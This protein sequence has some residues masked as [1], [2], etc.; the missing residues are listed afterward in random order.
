M[1]SF[2]A[3]NSDVAEITSPFSGMGWGAPAL[4]AGKVT[5][6]PVADELPWTKRSIL[7]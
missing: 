7:A 1:E 3:T 4:Q 5:W 6:E 2:L